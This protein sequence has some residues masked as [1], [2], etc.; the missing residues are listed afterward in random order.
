LGI[1]VLAGET[2]AAPGQEPA[3]PVAMVSQSLAN[4]LGGRQVIGKHIRVGDAGPYQR[5]KVIGISADAQLSL[6]DPGDTRPLSVYVNLWQFADRRHSPTLL[7]K[8]GTGALPAAAEI[9]RVVQA[10]G[11]DYIEHIVTLEAQ[12]T[13]A[14]IENQWL[15]WLSAAFGVLALALA[16]TGLFGLLS[17]HVA[18]RTA[19]IGL[20]MA[21]GAERPAIHRLVLQQLLPV[22]AT[23]IAAGLAL[24]L[25]LARL[26]SSLIFGVSVYDPRLLAASVIVLALTA[27]GAAWLPARKAASI[28]PLAALRHD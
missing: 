13:Q 16:A 3:E 4:L 5:L 27:L 26:F 14:L 8:A 17:Y 20:R 11:R 21:L 7:V 25:A 23:G 10:G 9:R 2:F 22:M 19:E 1:P 6:E 18:S 28:D 12:R 15:A 24:A